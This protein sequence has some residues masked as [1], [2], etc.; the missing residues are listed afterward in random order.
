MHDLRMIREA[1]DR[2]DQG[3]ERRG[4]APLSAHILDLDRRRR[5]TQTDLQEMQTRRNAVSKQVG[6]AKRNGE[7]ARALIEEVQKLKEG[8]A[9]DEGLEKTLDAELVKLLEGLPNLPAADVPDGDSEDDNR[10]VRV[11]GDKPEFAFEPKEHFDLGEALGQMDFGAAARLSGA[12]F[13][14][15][16][17]ALARLE[18]SLAAFMLDLHTQ[19]HGFKEIVTPVLVR[20]EALYGTGQL[21][22]FTEDLYR[23]SDDYWLIPT[24]EVTLT[25]LAGEGILDEG[26]LPLRMTAWTQCFRSEAGAAGKDTRG[27][28]RQH[29]FSKVEM[30]CVTHPDNSNAELERMT[31]CAEEVLKRLGLPYRVVVLCAGDMGFGAKKT[32]DIEVWLPGQ[33]TYREISS[34]SNCG[35]FQ[36]RRMKARYRPRGEKGTRFVHT[37]NGSGLAVGR[38]MIAV[39]ENYQNEDGSITVPEVLR[40]YMGGLECITLD[41]SSA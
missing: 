29:Q 25:N 33:G 3:L 24:A 11:Q 32:Y 27:M 30:V 31:G 38:T 41:V 39:L 9:G 23:T 20:E 36:A 14:V 1:P 15:L 12:R 2:F 16:S 34:C 22:K 26:G 4:L 7:D 35:D 17:G 40:P 18:R 8:I 19:E 21:P 13:V 28:L 10:E 6:A 37:L 5:A